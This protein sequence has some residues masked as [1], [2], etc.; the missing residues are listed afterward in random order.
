MGTLTNLE[1]GIQIRLSFIQTT[2][3]GDATGQMSHIAKSKTKHRKTEKEVTEKQNQS[4][5]E[6]NR[7]G[8]SL[9][10]ANTL[11]NSCLR[12][13]LGQLLRCQLQHTDIALL[14]CHVG[15]GDS[16]LLL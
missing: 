5:T 4:K 12:W 3:K 7:N 15:L 6:H 14:G 2:N 8:R 13:Q 10:L 1:Q 9:H 11:I 16:D